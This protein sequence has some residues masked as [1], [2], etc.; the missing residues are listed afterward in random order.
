MP[1]QATPIRWR[2]VVV[3]GGYDSYDVERSIL[4]DI[5][6][7]VAVHPCAGDV[8]KVVRVAAD[9]DAV[10]VR[11]TPLPAAVLDSLPRCRAIVRYGVGT[12]HIDLDH[13]ARLGIA[14]ANVPDYG[15]NEVAEHALAMLLA[16]K[17]HL[18]VRDAALR[19]GG[20][21]DARRTPIHRTAGLTLG[22][23]GAGR[24]GLA[25]LEKARPL[26]FRRILVHSRDGAPPGTEAADVDTVCREA[27]ALSL[28]LPL[29]PETQGLIGPE[30]LALMKP[31]AILINTARGG[32]IDEEALA[33]ALVEG[34]IGGAG[35]DVF[36]HEPIQASNPLLTAPNCLLTDH[37]AWYSEE[38]VGDLQRLAAEEVRRMLLGE[39][40]VNRVPPTPTVPHREVAP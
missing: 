1:A 21:G 38:A 10:L 9:A 6:A 2:V 27:D 35:I 11:E 16:V 28:H 20:W 19:A 24:I 15:V 32:L 7:E 39:P 25:F 29:T 31:G 3:D 18:T 17:R 5:G 22:L 40:T 13:A 36:E 34:R 37:V 26:G 33:R 8:D 30:R 23:I 4:A 14:V 12:D